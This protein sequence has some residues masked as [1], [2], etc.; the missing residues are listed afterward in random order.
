M[1]QQT[2]KA[3][4]FLTLGDQDGP[5]GTR[6][7]RASENTRFM[8]KKSKAEEKPV[9]DLKEVEESGDAGE[10]DFNSSFDL[11]SSMQDSVKELD[12]P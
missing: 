3:N 11:D 9:F 1:K 7:G 6:V 2:I 10:A 5:G 4:N 12:D 8:Q